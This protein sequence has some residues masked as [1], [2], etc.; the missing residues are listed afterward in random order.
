MV[1]NQSISQRIDEL[2]LEMI[3]RPK[4]DAPL[5]HL[6]TPG[7]YSRTIFMPEDTLITSRIHKTRHQFIISEG[8]AW[9]KV[10]DNK[11]EKLV[12]PFLGITEPGTRRVLYIEQGCVWTTFHP[13]SIQPENDTEEA[14]LDAV[15]KI[16]ELIIEPH[17]NE[18]LGGEMK[19]NKL[20]QK[21]EN[22]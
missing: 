3:S 14:V 6:F 17:V 11:W 12:A 22:Q 2:E 8:I 15:A 13:T 9:V 19:N 7:M 5:R 20:F 16:E 21:I 1:E 4:V 10:N 18:L